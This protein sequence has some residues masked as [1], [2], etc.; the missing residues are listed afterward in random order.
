MGFIRA[1]ETKARQ[2][3]KG[4]RERQM[5]VHMYGGNSLENVNANADR[6]QKAEVPGG[7]SKVGLFRITVLVVTV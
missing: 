6:T 2:Y 5:L 7:P 4:K 3:R 1:I